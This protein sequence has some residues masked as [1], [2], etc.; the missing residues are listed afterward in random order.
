MKNNLHNGILYE[1]EFQ[2]EALRRG[3]IPNVP[4]VPSLWDCIISCPRGLLRVQVKG[5]SKLHIDD[6]GYKIMT[7]SGRGHKT[8]IKKSVDV[9]A[10]WI[11]PTRQ[12]Y[13]IPTTTDIPL[14]IRITSQEG[15]TSKYE[16]YRNNWSP[17]YI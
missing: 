17:F 1:T 5:T 11:D 6:R 7:C 12:W 3:F 10:C 14:T 13:L 15:S 16:K 4:T 9:L 8:K 2:S